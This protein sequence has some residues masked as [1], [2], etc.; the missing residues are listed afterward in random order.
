MWMWQWLG[1]VVVQWVLVGSVWGK[2]L[3]DLGDAEAVCSLC[4][5]CGQWSYSESLLVCCCC[6][7]FERAAKEWEGF[8]PA[9]VVGSDPTV[10]SSTEIHPAPRRGFSSVSS[11]SPSSC[12]DVGAWGWLWLSNYRSFTLDVTLNP[13]VSLKWQSV[14]SFPLKQARCYPGSS[15]GCSAP[16]IPRMPREWSASWC[17]MLSSLC[18]GAL[19]IAV[20]TLSLQADG[21]SAISENSFI[22]WCSYLV[23]WKK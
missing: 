9:D 20:Q 22:N 8:G 13:A 11:E 19:A 5:P 23:S 15:R 14:A 7:T 12:R 18:I 2:C 16:G 3:I 21:S 4:F 6:G 1:G 10:E 17:W